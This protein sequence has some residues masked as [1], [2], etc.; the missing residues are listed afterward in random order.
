MGKTTFNRFFDDAN[1]PKGVHMK[2]KLHLLVLVGVLLSISLAM[3]CYAD[4]NDRIRM[5]NSL[6]AKWKSEG[7]PAVFKA[8]GNDNQILRITQNNIIQ[9]PLLTEGQL[10]SLLGTYL[11]SGV[12]E[13]LKRMGFMSGEVVDGRHRR[14][15]FG[16]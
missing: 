5:A 3:N 16:L 4:A 7:S 8:T 14:Y 2:Y 13:K 15:P 9:E 12:Q 1:H 6:T 11:E 10:V